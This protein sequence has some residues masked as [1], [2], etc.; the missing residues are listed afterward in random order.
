ML[1]VSGSFAE[2]K[3]VLTDALLFRFSTF[4][5]IKRQ[6]NAP[7]TPSRLASSLLGYEFKLIQEVHWPPRKSLDYVL[8]KS[9]SI[10]E[11]RKVHEK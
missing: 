8:A 5:E 7:A 10:L 4:L 2:Q 11:K 3:D 9:F 1:H 6:E